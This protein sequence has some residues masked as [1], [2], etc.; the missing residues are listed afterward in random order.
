M[1]LT[2]AVV[3]AVTFI[4]SFLNQG[5]KT[6]KEAEKTLSEIRSLVKNLN[7]LSQTAAEKL[8]DAGSII[9]DTKKAASS[10]S[11]ATGLF[12]TK[13]LKPAAQIWPYLYPAIKLVRRQMKKKKKKKQK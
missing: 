10:L 1:V 5:K 4:V 6:V 8:K 3:V 7:E 13:I 12:T 9:D 11:D 2:I